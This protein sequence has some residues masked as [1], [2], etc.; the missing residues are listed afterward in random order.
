MLP[1]LLDSNEIQKYIKI[2]K[3]AKGK[4]ASRRGA[5]A[6]NEKLRI[7]L[8]ISRKLGIT[9]AYLCLEND[10][11]A[12]Y[13]ETEIPFENTLAGVDF[14]SITLDFEKM[15]TDGDG[16]FFWKIKLLV[17]S[18]C[19]FSH[20]INNVDYCFSDLDS[21]KAFRLLVYNKDFSTPEWAKGAVMYQIFVDRFCKGN[22]KV[23][24]RND[25]KINND[26]YDGIPEFAAKNGDPLENNMFFGG[27][28]WGVV[29]KLDYLKGLGV[30]IIYLCPIFKAFSNH[31]Y[32]TGDYET[33]DEMFGGEE[34]FHE[35]V[36][37]AKK[38]GMHIILDGV[39]NHTGDDS[40]YFNRYGKYESVGAYQSEDSEYSDWYNFEEFPDKYEAW[41]GIEILPRLMG[42][43]P[44][45]MDYF[46]SDNGIVR[47]W[48]KMGIS[49][50]R[51]DVADELSENFLEE[52]NRA[53]KQ[54][55]KDALIIG[56][57]WENAADKVSYGK[58]RK[59]FR[60]G[61]LDSVMN[62]P[63]KY[64]IIDF[65]KDK[66]AEKFYN[67]VTDIYSSYP[68]CCS[69]VLMNLVGSHDTER[70][71]TILGGESPEGKTNAELS[72]KKMTPEQLSDGIR[73]LKVAS[74]LQFTLPGIPM[75][76]YGDEAGLE[77]YHDPFCRKP[78]PWGRENTE[79]VNHYTRLSHIKREEASLCNS[80]LEFVIHNDGLVVYKRGDITV[81][82]NTSDSE[83][84]LELKGKYT[85]LLCGK[86]E[87]NEISLSPMSAKILK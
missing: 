40:K 14:Y 5:F 2:K 16:L 77:G 44:K 37:Q 51:L 8:E 21:S 85:E 80:P 12:T 58:R 79:L 60:G 75:I 13:S 34:A 69:D 28:L 22:K 78:Y 1:H 41:W 54:E 68:Q 84:C 53:A 23:P 56:E 50:W 64:A 35:L 71:L 49:G 66:N 7:E 65:V 47:K 20:S 6:G 63:V 73:K 24:I 11:N 76:Y 31:K 82:V 81:A 10:N 36:K 86:A 55:K 43:N 67:S 25:S 26:W 87:K 29:E 74:V 39:F 59:Y 30:N 15:C 57:V 18:R 38:R 33:V 83:K 70:I 9:K 52:L 46:L 32:D 42:D 17:G 62:Y 19:F 45:V 27:T 72:T 61:Q 48:I 4:C 3:T